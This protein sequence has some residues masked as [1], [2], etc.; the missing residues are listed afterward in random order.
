M[1]LSLIYCVAVLSLLCG[2]FSNA[3][4]R[5]DS[6]DP[7]SG[8]G[9]VSPAVPCDLTRFGERCE[10]GGVCAVIDPCGGPVPCFDGGCP[11]VCEP[12]WGCV[13]PTPEGEACTYDQGLCEAGTRCRPVNDECELVDCD[14]N[15]GSCAQSCE[16]LELA[17]QPILEAASCDELVC[18]RGEVCKEELNT[19]CAPD[20]PC[21]ETRTRAYCAID[22][23][24][25]EQSCLSGRITCGYGEVCAP[26]GYRVIHP[27]N[28]PP[29]FQAPWVC[30]PSRLNAC[31]TVSCPETYTCMEA[32][33]PDG[34]IACEGKAC[35]IVE[36][37]KRPVCV[38][39]PIATTCDPDNPNACGPEELCL[40]D[41]S[42]TCRD[43]YYS[44]NG[45]AFGQC[46][47]EFTCQSEALACRAEGQRCPSGKTCQVAACEED[48]NDE[49]A[50][51]GD[52]CTARF[53]CVE[54]TEPFSVG[55]QCDPAR[56]QCEA[57]L[58]CRQSRSLCFE[59]TC[60]NG[61]PGCATRE[62]NYF[63]HYPTEGASCDDIYCRET[64]ACEVEPTSGQARCVMQFSPGDCDPSLPD[65]CANGTVCL[66]DY[67]T[68][69]C[70][71]A[72]SRDATCT[73]PYRCQSSR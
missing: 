50:C 73:V 32:L 64:E 20:Q 60:P 19:D 70:E 58:E 3:P 21:D 1:K 31:N 17:C 26:D 13:E 67:E 42:V 2:C 51:N 9:C 41:T 11:D 57:G 33:G 4:P 47:E 5:M 56:G 30:Q 8:A 43:Q 34:E 39:D 69:V 28:Q 63:C 10:T 52:G 45:Q 37:S 54:L 59:T 7:C 22:E 71:G 72:C 49:N 18:R 14:P 53:E 25:N 48:C 62:M 55:Y 12:L 35:D 38:A 27:G 23:V 36:S 40:A 15:T 24:P 68:P 46:L 65:A 61:E 44:I 16:T 6:P 29:Y 66:P